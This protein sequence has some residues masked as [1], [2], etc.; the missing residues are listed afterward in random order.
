MRKIYYLLFIFILFGCSEK[1]D[2]IVA[3]TS[4]LRI[5]PPVLKVFSNTSRELKA[6]SMNSD[7]KDAQVVPEWSV[8]P[9]TLGF[10]G[11]P[12][13]GKTGLFVAGN[14]DSDGKVYADYNG[15]RAEVNVKVFKEPHYLLSDNDASQYLKRDSGNNVILYYFD[16]DNAA[17]WQIGVQTAVP[18]AP[19][20]A[21]SCMK[22]D[23]TNTA[24]G[25]GGIFLEFNTPR[26]FSL[27]SKLTFWVRGDVGSENFIV[28][29]D[30]GFI[31]EK[32]YSVTGITSSWQKIEIPFSGW[33][34]GG[35]I[36]YGITKPFI[37]A[38]S[39]TVTGNNATI[40]LDAIAFEK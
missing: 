9:A 2:R 36:P 4:T 6:I 29:I 10:M 39:D 34:N 19:G 33:N 15:V 11:I 17:P 5:D 27:F 32:E 14:S 37:I 3:N 24:G 12:T 21:A 22:I 8:Y 16:T 18:G 30:D 38:F 23:Y 20:D 1:K 31:P 25:W 13:T 26:D 35:L 7:M 28:K 40:Y